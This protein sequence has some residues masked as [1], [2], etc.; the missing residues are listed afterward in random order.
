VKS[1]RRAPSQEGRAAHDIKKVVGD[2]VAGCAVGC[3]AR[4]ALLYGPE[5]ANPDQSSLD[6]PA[7]IAES[8][9][10]P[11][12]I[13]RGYLSAVPPLLD[14]A[15]QI[16]PSL[17]REG[18]YEAL[19]LSRH[20]LPRHRIEKQAH[21]IAAFRE[22]RVHTRYAQMRKALRIF[23]VMRKAHVELC[24][25]RAPVEVLTQP[26]EPAAVG[27]ACLRLVQCQPGRYGMANG[28]IESVPRCLMVAIDDPRE[29]GQRHVSADNH[30]VDRIACTR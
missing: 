22:R 2:R 6:L 13:L 9:G 7:G 21:D 1:L 10:D 4:I 20:A 24:R 16:D 25:A 3:L 30:A 23:A 8:C 11:A 26:R 5:D 29:V 17:R 14:Q 28:L 15:E 27:N 12:Q 19:L 18:V